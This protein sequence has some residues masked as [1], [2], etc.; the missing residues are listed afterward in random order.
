LHLVGSFLLLKL[1]SESLLLSCLSFGH[2]LCF[3]EFLLGDFVFFCLIFFFGFLLESLDLLC[4]QLVDLLLIL[5]SL[6]SIKLSLRLFQFLM[7]F[8][9]RHF[10]SLLGFLFSLLLLELLLSFNLSFLLFLRLSLLLSFLV[11]LLVV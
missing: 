10:L 9:L 11:L 6:F 8:S 3:L 5:F 1:L 7:C 4:L 2:S